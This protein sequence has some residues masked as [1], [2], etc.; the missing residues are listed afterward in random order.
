MLKSRP[1]VQ[2]THFQGRFDARLE[3]VGGEG[4]RAVSY[5]KRHLCLVNVTI[6]AALALR[7]PCDERQCFIDRVEFVAEECFVERRHQLSF[8]HERIRFVDFGVDEKRTPIV[9][10]LRTSLSRT[11]QWWRW[12][13]NGTANLRQ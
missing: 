3:C 12:H 10:T 6:L 11:F 1:R 5:P 2:P 9:V 7:S 8:P 4:Y 13:A